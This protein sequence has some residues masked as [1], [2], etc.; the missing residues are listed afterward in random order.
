M[1]CQNNYTNVLRYAARAH[2][3][4]V[5]FED[6]PYMTHVV[7]VTTEVIH[8]CIESNIDDKKTDFA[9]TV[10]LLHDILEKTR[11]TYDDILDKYGYEVAQGVDSMTKNYDLEKEEQFEDNMK[12]LLAQ[13]TE[14]QMIKLAD[15]INNLCIEPEFWDDDEI[16]SYVKDSKLIYS[17]LK[18]SNVYL[19]KRLNDKI[20]EFEKYLEGNK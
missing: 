10:S 15:R 11:T 16:E 13:P 19:A 1:F 12:R 5:T 3:K 17:Y 2:A 9:I 20:L 7:G 4:Q 18:D 14:I 6:L 8:A